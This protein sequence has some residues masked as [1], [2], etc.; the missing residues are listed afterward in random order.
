MLRALREVISE[1]RPLVS[2]PTDFD[3]SFAS[4]SKGRLITMLLFPF[5]LVRFLGASFLRPSWRLQLCTSESPGCDKWFATYR[6]RKVWAKNVNRYVWGFAVWTA[7]LLTGCAGE[8]KGLL[9]PTRLHESNDQKSQPYQAGEIPVDDYY[10]A[11]NLAKPSYTGNTVP[12]Q[13]DPAIIKNYIYEGVGLVDAYCGRWF[14]AIEDMQRQGDFTQKNVNVIQQLGTTLMGVGQATPIWVTGYGAVNTAYSGLANNFN[15]AFL[16]GPTTKK[17]KVEIFDLLNQSATELKNKAPTMTFT[18]AYSALEK[19]A[20]ICTFATIRDVL[21]ASLS[22]P[23]T[24]TKIDP[25][26]GKITVTSSFQ[27]DDSSKRLLMYWM[28]DGKVVNKANE[29]ALKAWMKK[30]QLD[31]VSIPFLINST[32]QASARQQAVK[33]LSIPEVTK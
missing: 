25:A 12:P 7:C 20:D 29:A 10:K 26:T 18:E 17:I 23:N 14:H 30:N 1:F 11:L 13:A 16:T 8:D 3:P 33:D 4:G 22:Q 2:K 5:H 28:P 9:N 19:H 32:T 24:Q 31:T 21:D 6:R 27:N 15:S